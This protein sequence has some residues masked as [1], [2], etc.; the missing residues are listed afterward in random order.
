MKVIY[1]V[2]AAILLSGCGKSG[3]IPHSEY[4]RI[5]DQCHKNDG[6]KS[7]YYREISRD[8]HI[9]DLIIGVECNDGAVFKEDYRESQNR[10][11]IED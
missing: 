1:I 8:S 9:Q 7:L 6:I 11:K 5:K 2:L 4:E 3:S 10:V